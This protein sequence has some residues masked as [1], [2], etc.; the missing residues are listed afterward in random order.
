MTIDAF[1]GVCVADVCTDGDAPGW[2]LRLMD[3]SGRFTVQVFEPGGRG[4]FQASLCETVD[5]AF[6]RVS[7]HMLVAHDLARTATAL[8]AAARAELA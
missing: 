2:R 5:D 3:E 6:D 8:I 7:S 1:D 4:T